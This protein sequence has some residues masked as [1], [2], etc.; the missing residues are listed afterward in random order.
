MV[1]QIM[2]ANSGQILFFAGSLGRKKYSFIE[3]RNERMMP[4]PLQSHPNVC[5]FCTIYV[6]FASPKFTQE[7]NT[8]VNHL[9]EI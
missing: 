6:A 7:E 3:K 4:E 1:H 8:G 5:G 2:S 9:N